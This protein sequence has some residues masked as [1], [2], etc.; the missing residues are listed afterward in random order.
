MGSLYIPKA[1]GKSKRQKCTKKKV[2][3][4][5]RDAVAAMLSA[6]DLSTRTGKRDVVFLTVLY[7]AAGRLDEIRSIKISHIH[8]DDPKPYLI[9]LGKGEKMRTAYLLPRAVANIRI[10]LK[11]FHGEKPEPEAYLFYSRVGGRN[12]KLSEP[13]L[14]KRIKLCAKTAHEKCPEVPLDAHAHQFRHARAS[15]WLE[16]GISIV[17]ISFLLGHEQLETTMKYLDI[18]TE[19][20]ANALST[21]EMEREKYPNKKWKNK[22][23]TLSEFCG[24]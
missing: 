13:A 2:C 10:Y 3:G 4:L 17:Q 7:A 20:K 19:E 12:T 18:T 1:V 14:D 22:D 16:D 5:T 8:L 21:L 11:E 6:P 9:L 23:G 15:H 24:L